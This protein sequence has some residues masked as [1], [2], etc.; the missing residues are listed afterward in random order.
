MRRGDIGQVP[1]KELRDMRGRGWLLS[2]GLAVLMAGLPPQ[3][4]TAAHAETNAGTSAATTADAAAM[5]A[6]EESL[7]LDAL[8]PV[9]AREG[10]NYGDDLD[11]SMFAGKGGVR[12]QAIVARIYEPGRLRARFS[13][14]LAGALSGKPQVV[15]DAQ[16]FFSSGTGQAIV[17]REVEAR[18]SLLN[19]DKKEAAEV[20]AEKLRDTRSPRLRLIRSLI[21][22]G[23]L[24]EGNVAS[25]LT[26]SAAFSEAVIATQPPEQR[27]PEADRMAQV[28]AQEGDIR[29]STTAWLLTFMVEAYAPLSDADLE[30]FVAFAK[31]DSGRALNQAL[32]AAYGETFRVVMQELGHEAGQVLLGSRI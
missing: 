4:M 17:A 30:R 14:N 12:W 1:A 19:P 15:A 7:G 3:M 9:L 2:A 25:G 18:E 28:W 20:A 32:F 5:A 8:F 27:L 6:L 10:Q 22:A 11:Q 13:A 26:G 31:S 24:V 29:A 23:D 16:A 21:E